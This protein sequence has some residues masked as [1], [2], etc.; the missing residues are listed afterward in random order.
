MSMT[1]SGRDGAVSYEPDDQ[2][3]TVESDRSPAWRS[4]E[5]GG[6]PLGWEWRYDLEPLPDGGT[7]VALTHDRRGTTDDNRARFG[8][9]CFGVRDLAAS[10][11]RLAAALTSVSASVSAAR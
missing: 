9:P 3:S 8:V 1:W 11:D 7:R 10:L 2:V 4:A 6:P 5:R